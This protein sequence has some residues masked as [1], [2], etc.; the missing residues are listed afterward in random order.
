MDISFLNSLI[1]NPGLILEYLA[2]FPEIITLFLVFLVLITGIYLLHSHNTKK[3][4]EIKKK[5]DL[6]REI[7]NALSDNVID[8]N[9]LL[10]L[11]DKAKELGFDET[12]L[13]KSISDTVSNNFFS[14]LDSTY[15]KN[16]EILERGLSDEDESA[17][18]SKA[19]SMNISNYREII[20]LDI[21]QLLRKIYLL[22]N[23]MISKLPVLDSLISLKKDENLY[24]E[25]DVSWN[26]LRKTTSTLG[27]GGI[28]TSI[29][30]VGNTKIRLGAIKPIKYTSEDMT[31]LDRGKLYITNKR[32]IFDGFKKN[33]SIT[34]GRVLKISASYQGI[35]V[36]KSSG[37]NDLFKM[38]TQTDVKLA[39]LYIQRFISS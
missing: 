34:Y 5:N 3:N 21:I 19:Q 12:Q 31:E 39:A 26:Q 37:K 35:E 33:T 15:L 36:T 20:E 32:I 16:E 28:T 7:N 17:I 27:F 25:T 10:V 30:I 1:N 38:G 8:E 24:F 14:W 9:E 11:Q 18:I 13:S 23:N 4:A 2:N 29:P 6:N 22:E